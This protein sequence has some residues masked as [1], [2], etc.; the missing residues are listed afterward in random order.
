[1]ADVAV[2][3]EHQ[4]DAIVGLHTQMSSVRALRKSTDLEKS[5]ATIAVIF[6]NHTGPDG[7][8]SKAQAKDLLL[9]QFQ[10]FIKGQELKPKYK[11]IISDLDEDKDR[12]IDFEDFMVLLTS[13]TI[14]SD[15][16]H[17]LRCITAKK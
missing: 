6:N 9:T 12:R 11:E 5:V 16:L 2:T 15:L 13:L 8:L 1:M 4:A 7:K 3:I 10:S 17:E 14:V